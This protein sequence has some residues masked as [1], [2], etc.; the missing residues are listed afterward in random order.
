MAAR[1][2]TI[3]RDSHGP[4]CTLGKLYLDGVYICETLENPWKDNRQR[5]S[6]IPAGTY[7]VVFRNEKTSQFKYKHLHVLQVPGRSLILVHI[8]N[9]A[10]D[11]LGCILTGLRRGINRVN[12][13]AIAFNKLME[14]LEGSAEM[15]LTIT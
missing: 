11:T 1:K 4:V 7:R 15:E 13:S 8:G 12:D 6:C 5:E 3:V 2:L 14:L 10:A 9:T